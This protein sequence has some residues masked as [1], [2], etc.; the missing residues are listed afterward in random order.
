MK[1]KD[2]K[3]DLKIIDDSFDLP[4]VV[5]ALINLVGYVTMALP[6][7][8]VLIALFLGMWGA[9]EVGDAIAAALPDWRAVATG[10]V[11]GVKLLVVLMAART[12]FVTLT[13]LPPFLPE[14]IE[15]IRRELRKD[16]DL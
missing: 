15:I 4:E 13:A 3:R 1:A 11:T 6:F 8:T 9:D 12:I 2:N 10:V 14:F 16:F 7:A 5:A